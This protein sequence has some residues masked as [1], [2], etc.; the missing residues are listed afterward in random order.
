MPRPSRQ[1]VRYEAH[2]DRRL[3]EVRARRDRRP[4][5]SSDDRTVDREACDGLLSELDEYAVEQAL[6]IADDADDVEVIALTRRPGRRGGRDRA[7]R[8]RWAPTTGIHVLDDDDPRLRRASRRRAVLA[9]AIRAGR[10]A[11]WWSAGWPRPTARWA[12]SRRCSP[13][14]SAGPQLT[15]GSTVETATDDRSRIRRDGDT[16]TETVQADLPLVL[17]VTDQSGEAR[18]PSFKG[19]MA[20]KKKPVE[21]LILD[22]LGIDADEVG[23]DAAWTKVEDTTARPPQRGRQDRHR[24]GRLGRQARWS[25]SSP[26]RSSSEPAARGATTHV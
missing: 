5:A 24:R 10:A 8:C 19:I 9:E 11:T 15:L 21:E 1:K 4:R 12:S 22:D 14:A 13:S 23:L 16:A 7:R 25:S 18:Y 20:A 2:E 6:Q 26:P 17:R 3:C